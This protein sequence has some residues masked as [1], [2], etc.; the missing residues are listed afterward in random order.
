MVN[1]TWN[2]KLVLLGGLQSMTKVDKVKE[3]LLKH[4]YIYLILMG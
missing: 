3:K 2:I 4:L 1:I